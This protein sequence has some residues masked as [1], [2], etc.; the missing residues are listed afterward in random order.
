[1]IQTRN[2]YLQFMLV[3]LAAWGIS[4]GARFVMEQAVLLYGSGKNY[5]FFSHGA[6]S[7]PMI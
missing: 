5:L 2:Q 4:W 1:M 6:V 7:A 3:M